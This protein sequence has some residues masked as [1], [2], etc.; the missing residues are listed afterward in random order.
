[1]VKKEEWAEVL[2]ESL[3]WRT[4]R[5]RPSKSTGKEKNTEKGLGASWTASGGEG[6]QLFNGGGQKGY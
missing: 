2:A 1:L 4:A 5:S 6:G 3:T